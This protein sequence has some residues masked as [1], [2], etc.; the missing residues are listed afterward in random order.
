MEP[1]VPQKTAKGK[2]ETVP[3]G[4][5]VRFF[6]YKE[7][8]QNNLKTFNNSLEKRKRRKWTR[9]S[10]RRKKTQMW[11]R[12]LEL[13]PPCLTL[14][15]P[16]GSSVHGILQARILEWGAMPFSRGS[17][18]TLGSN[19]GLLHCREILYHW[20]PWWGIFKPT[21]TQKSQGSHRRTQDW[22][23]VRAGDGAES[24]ALRQSQPLAVGRGTCIR[25][26]TRGLL[27]QES[28]SAVAPLN[29]L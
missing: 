1:K 23:Q 22:T 18:P 14:C 17:F 13:A 15:D 8:L 28:R 5:K 2:T 12:M 11:T 3:C 16:P 9:N 24:T 4:K 19:P 6:V 7:S 21:C 27:W 25:H 26:D 10:P 20:E 29:S